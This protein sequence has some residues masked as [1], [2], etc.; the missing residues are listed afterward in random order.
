MTQAAGGAS[1]APSYSDA[2][3]EALPCD[4][5]LHPEVSSPQAGKA[6]LFPAACTWNSGEGSFV[7]VLMGLKGR[8]GGPHSVRIRMAL[9]AVRGAF[10]KKGRLGGLAGAT[11]MTEVWR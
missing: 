4:L 10:A 1:C 3:C 9:S 2:K 8:L 6:R 11:V 5:A 7:W